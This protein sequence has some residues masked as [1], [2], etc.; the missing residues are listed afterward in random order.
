M[1]KCPWHDLGYTLSA[2]FTRLLT[3]SASVCRVEN[4]L[5]ISP[6]EETTLPIYHSWILQCWYGSTRTSVPL[7]LWL[8]CWCGF[9]LSYVLLPLPLHPHQSQISVRATTWPLNFQTCELKKPL[10]LYKAVLLHVFYCSNYNRNGQIHE[11][12]KHLLNITKL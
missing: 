7:R 1:I 8:V 10:Y 6:F 11:F 4:R 9:S 5:Y 3:T 2:K 12:E